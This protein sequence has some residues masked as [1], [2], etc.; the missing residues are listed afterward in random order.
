MRFTSIA[1][2]LAAFATFSNA[3]PTSK[4]IL[5]EKRDQP[6]SRY[7]RG[8]RADAQA[9]L[10][11][12]IGLTQ[13]NLDE[14]SVYAK[15][16]DVAHPASPNFGKHW[17]AADVHGAFAPTEETMESVKAWLVAAGIASERIRHYENRAWLAFEGTVAEAEALFKTEYYEHAHTSRNELRV[18]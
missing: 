18:G 11:I 14:E 13:T 6:L 10:P 1:A 15:L 8:A 4:A 12:R 2:F 17:S 7:V 5:H 16:M 9:V 3:A